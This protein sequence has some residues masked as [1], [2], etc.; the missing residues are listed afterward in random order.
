M[1]SSIWRALRGVPPADLRAARLQ[2]HYAAQWLAR[3]A[4]AHIMAMPDDGHT[5]LGW[6]DAFGGFITHPHPD[7]ARLG[8][9]IGDLTLAL[10]GASGSAPAETFA[11]GG[12]READA[13]DWLGRMAQK[14]GLDPRGFDAPLPYRLTPHPLASGGAYTPAALA[15][16]LAELAR[17]YANANAALGATR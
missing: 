11:L 8:L 6:D 12:R 9:R 2:A 4:R 15:G 5:N 17:W 7:D 13:R 14:R 1:S 10:L 3:A 16:P